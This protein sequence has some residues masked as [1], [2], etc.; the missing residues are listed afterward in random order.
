MPDPDERDS[1]NRKI[2]DALR[3]TFAVIANRLTPEVEPATIYRL[4]EPVS[5]P[6]SLMEE[7]E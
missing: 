4:D 6:S 7:P 2:V 3:K 5:E 1:P